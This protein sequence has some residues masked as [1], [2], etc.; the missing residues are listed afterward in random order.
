MTENQNKKFPR[1]SKRTRMGSYTFILTAIILAVL[2]ILNLLVS[3]IPKK[4]TSFDTSP[5]KLYTISESNTKFISGL[6]E[7]V[8][9]YWV[10]PG[11]TPQAVI[12]P[13]VERYT[14]L[15]SHLSLK[16]LDPIADPTA[17]SRFNI[18]EGELSDFS[19]ILESA[20]RFRIVDFNNMV[21]YYNEYLASALYQSFGMTI[22]PYS[23][24]SQYYAYFASAEQNG[25]PTDELFYGDHQLSKAVEYVTLESIPRIYILEGHGENSFS[26]TFLGFISDNNIEY[27][28]LRLFDTGKVPD[29]ANCV[30][31]FS[32]ENDI[33]ESERGMLREY[34][35][36]GGN[37]LLITSPDDTDLTNLLSLVEPYGVSALPGMVY[38]GNSAR[39][40][41]TEYNLKPLV[42]NSHFTTAYS[43]GYTLLMPKAHAI[44]ISEQNGGATVTK[45]FTTSDKA[46]L[47]NGDDKSDDG[48]LTI[49]VAIEKEASNGKKTQIIWYS[50][51]EAFTDS[52]A[53]SVSYGNYN[54]FFYTLFWMNESYD[55]SLADVEGVSLTEPIL[56]GLSE[57]SVWYWAAIFVIVIP[58]TVI[59]IGLVVWLRRKKR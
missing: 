9:I 8:T 21:G 19:F 13:F 4:Y 47:K 40:I 42:N 20:K 52:A 39:Y 28:S 50:S 48:T 11:G 10:C 32:P 45:L 58:V 33:S 38:E 12:E 55:S 54:Y 27:E 43:V 35:N 59:V 46:Y 53:A 2:V 30:V 3:A 23:V 22:V 16:I 24:Y 49:G 37:M 15:S 36:N 56:D 18:K 31:I 29:S 44:G 1:L 6:T 7:D 14:E 5:N 34:L 51:A 57:Q 17:L 41:D 26:E 25:Y